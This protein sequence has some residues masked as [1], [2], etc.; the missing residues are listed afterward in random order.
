MLGEVIS[1][2]GPNHTNCCDRISWASSTSVHRWV[3]PLNFNPW[4]MNMT[5][6]KIIQMKN[7]YIKLNTEYTNNSQ[8]LKSTARLRHDWYNT[9]VIDCRPTELVQKQTRIM[10]SGKPCENVKQKMSPKY[11]QHLFRNVSVKLCV[12]MSCLLQWDKSHA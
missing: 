10:S 3:I 5:L 6:F 2:A 9:I 8:C 11:I 1:T 12:V 7:A 4:Q